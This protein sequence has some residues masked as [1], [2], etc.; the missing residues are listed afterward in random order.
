MQDVI[1]LECNQII[2][3]EGGGECRCGMLSCGNVC[4]CRVCRSIQYGTL[5][6][7]SLELEE[8]IKEFKGKEGK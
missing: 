1:M 3:E 2:D 8:K 5:G 4:R 6:N 7:S